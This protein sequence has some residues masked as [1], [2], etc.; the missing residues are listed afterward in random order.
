MLYNKK[1][2]ASILTADLGN[3]Q[4]N[5]LELEKTSV[6]IIHFDV[7]DGHFVPNITFGYSLIQSLR[8]PLKSTFDV[9]LMITNPEKYLDSFIKAGANWISFH[10]EAT[11]QKQAINIC[12]KL[13]NNAIQAGIAISPQTKPQ[14]IFPILNEIDFVLIMTVQPG[15]GGQA[16]IPEC[17]TKIKFLKENFLKKNLPIKIEIDGGVNKENIAKLSTIGADIFVAGSA[18]FN[19]KLSIPKAVQ[20]LT[21]KLYSV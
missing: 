12:R 7:M 13:K 1:I 2:A 15:F 14:A 20:S 17:L 8:K 16:I 10:Y 18:I 19:K 11:N 5:L 6:D 21:D 4:Q 3:L 9:H